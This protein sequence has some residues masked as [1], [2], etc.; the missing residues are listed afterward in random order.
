MATMLFYSTH[1][2]DDPTRATLP[3]VLTSGALDAGHKPAVV[4]VGEAVVVMRDTIAENIQGVGL[5]PLKELLAKAV[6]NKV[7]IYV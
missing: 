2:S 3:F 5:P 6:Q 4:L 7:P 1:G